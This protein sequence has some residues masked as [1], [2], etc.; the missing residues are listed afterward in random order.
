[1]FCENPKKFDSGYYPCGVCRACRLK[2]AHEKF[3]VSIFAGAEYRKKGQFL[4]LTYRDEDRPNGLCYSDFKD[5]MKRLRFIDGTTDVK[6]HVAGEYGE[7]THR[8]HFHVLFYNYKY[9]INLVERCWNKGFVYDG[10]LTPK[11]MKYV[12]GYIC[13]RGYEPDSGK[14]PPFGRTSINLPDGLTR[15]ELTQMCMTG[16]VSYN[17]VLYS[18]PSNW[19]RRYRPIW[20]AFERERALFKRDILLDKLKKNN[21]DF[22]KLDV[23]KDIVR[24]KMDFRDMVRSMTKRKEV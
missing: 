9:D 15:E 1:M 16:K 19:R 11:S 18:A 21:Y 22:S 8:E 20:E 10:T 3:I 13:K 4:T 6:F 23:D 5:F 2:R 17:G 24:S 7:H 12:S 14:R